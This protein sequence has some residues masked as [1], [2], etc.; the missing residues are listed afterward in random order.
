MAA[1]TVYTNTD[2]VRAALGLD[3]DHY[4]VPDSMLV[5]RN[6]DLELLE[7]LDDWLPTHAAIWAAA[8]AGS[9]SAAEI[10]AGRQL[11]LYAMWFCAAMLAEV[12]LAMPS[13]ISDGQNRVQ[14]FD[15]DLEKL[16]E[17]ARAKRDKYKEQIVPTV[18]AATF[19]AGVSPDYDPVTG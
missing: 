8:D 16:L 12:W 7:D 11:Q 19:I 1:L 6:M 13:S 15:L 17:N 14:R 18:S 4:E 5:N 3:A 10:R 2:A 9:P